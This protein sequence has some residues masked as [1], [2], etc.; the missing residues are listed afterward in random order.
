M[1]HGFQ[2]KVCGLRDPG[3]IRAIA[4]L[5]PDAMGFIFY[6]PSK[7]F[8]GDLLSPAVMQELPSTIDKVGVFVNAENT[9]ILS[10]SK[11]YGL[12]SIQLHGDEPCEQLAELR[13]AAPHLSLWKAFGLSSGFD[14]SR[15]TAYEPYCDTFLFDTKTRSYGGSG[16]TFDWSILASYQG[17]KPFWLS[18]GLGLPHVPAILSFASSAPSFYGVDLN[19][20]LE[21][22][23]GLKSIE[24]TRQ[25]LGDLRGE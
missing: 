11:R 23:P 25:V 10:I 7:R 21:D 8:V 12:G 22:S 5:Q 24:L 4:T 18:G 16:Q 17:T 3:N 14:F 13:K 19:S 15:L 1:K 20:Q 9:E 6:P 2:I